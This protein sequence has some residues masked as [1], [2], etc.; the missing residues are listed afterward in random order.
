LGN[1]DIDNHHA[2]NRI[3]EVP[4]IKSKLP[5]LAALRKGHILAAASGLL[6]FLCFFGLTQTYSRLFISFHPP[7]SNSSLGEVYLWLGSIIFLFPAACLLG[8]GAGPWLA[9]RL[10]RA[11]KSLEEMSRKDQMII[12]VALSMIFLALARILH[13]L[14]LLDFPITDD[15]YAARFG[16]QVLAMGKFR[17]PCPEPFAAFPQLFLIAKDGWVACKDWIGSQLGWAVAEITRTGALFFAFAAAVPALFLALIMRR[18]LS[19]GYGVAAL[20]LFVCSPMALALSITTHA[21][22]LSRAMLAVTIFLYIGAEEKKKFLPWLW[23]GLAAGLGFLC[24]PFETGFILLPLFLYVGVRS[25][26]GNRKEWLP[27]GG[28]L[29][30]GLG[31]LIVFGLHNWLLQGNILLP[32]YFASNDPAMMAAGSSL[33][34]RFGANTSYNLLMLAIWFLGPAGILLASLG[35]FRDT[36]TRLMGLGVVSVLAAGLLHDNY[37][38]HIV[39]PIHYSECAVPLVILAV[40]GI[41][42]L[43]RRLATRK[44]AFATLGCI[45]V[46]ILV[47]ELG[48]FNL[49]NFRALNRQATIQSYIYGFI[50]EN[51]DQRGVEKAVILAPQFGSLWSRNA[52]FRNIGSFV[53]EWR[54]VR[55]DLQDKV[56]ILHG[57]PNASEVLKKKFP[58]RPFFWI[59]NIDKPPFFEL[60]PIVP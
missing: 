7:F 29:T 8:Y 26:T 18:R 52:S 42:E 56:M 15:E 40:H 21:H 47:L 30:G 11:W 58:D 55:P 38:L 6:L 2:L 54:R 44:G 43:R 31:P 9:P 10:A 51:L 45:L 36:F 41:D 46:S 25:F 24:R 1:E 20:V 3:K 28:L 57:I 53:F 17:A 59:G 19:M 27:V 4:N 48:T 5:G 32:A 13:A 23:T 60:T 50:Q 12:L 33:W 39:G 35:V 14:V 34:T 16:G 22:L 49:W 37:G